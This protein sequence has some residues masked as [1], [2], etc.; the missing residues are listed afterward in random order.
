[1]DREG[2]Y[3]PWCNLSGEDDLMELWCGHF[4]YT[5]YDDKLNNDSEDEQE[6]GI[7]TSQTRRL[8]SQPIL[9]VRRQLMH[10]PVQR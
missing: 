8:R 1:M 5:H 2:T 7:H 3:W 6:S 10:R 9:Q 4:L